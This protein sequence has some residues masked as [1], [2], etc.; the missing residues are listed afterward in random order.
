MTFSALPLLWWNLSVQGIVLPG[1]GRLSLC[2][3]LVLTPLCF[4][5]LV[6]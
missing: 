1:S 2:V 5:R 3:L 6:C 4:A